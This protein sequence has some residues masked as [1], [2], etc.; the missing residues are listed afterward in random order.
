MSTLPPSVCVF[1]GARAGP[2]LNQLVVTRTMHER[3]ELMFAN[4][5]AV[6]VLPGGAGSLD[7]FFEVLTWR[8]LGLHARPILLL[9]AHDY[10]A[11]LLALIDHV[12]AHGFADAGLRD[13]VTPCADVAAAERALAARLDG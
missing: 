2:D 8:Q 7:E 6:V 10:W 11:P 5:H 1:C 3:K 4:S 13:A 12:I 9:G